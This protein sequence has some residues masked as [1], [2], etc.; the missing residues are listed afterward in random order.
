M[1]A[2]LLVGCSS[3]AP[4]KTG[5]KFTGRVLLLT[6]DTSKGAA[7][8]ELTQSGDGFSLATITPGVLRR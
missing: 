7:L 1:T 6:G 2:G 3:E 5:P 8:A 4:K